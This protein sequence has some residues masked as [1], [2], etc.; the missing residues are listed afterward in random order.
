[1][2][3][4]YSFIFFALVFGPAVC[5]SEMAH[6]QQGPSFDCTKAESSAEELVCDNV[7]LATLDRRLAERYAAARA[8]ISALEADSEDAM[9]N[10]LATQR[11]WVKGRDDCWKATDLRTCVA[12]NYLM[13][14][15]ELVSQWLLEQPKAVVTYTCDGSPANEVTAYFFDTELPSLR[16]EYGDSIRSGWLVPAA[17]GAKYA[18]DFGGSFWSKGDDAQFEPTEGDVV[19]CEKAS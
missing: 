17:S 18:I 14:E 1:M 11:G 12:D 19:T 5:V 7:D 9:N 8:A 3:A 13:R 10:L 4:L 16:L 15:G 2:P 6:A